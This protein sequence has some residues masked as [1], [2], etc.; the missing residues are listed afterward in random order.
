MTKAASP[1]WKIPPE[2]I[3]SDDCAVYVGRVIEDGEIKDEGTAY[4]VHEGEWVEML[5]CR[6]LSELL[7]LTDVEKAA[8]NGADYLRILCQELSQR[9]TAW[10]WTGMAGEA[11]PEPYNAPAVLERLTDDELM[12]LLSA[13]KGNE[14]SDA[15][16]NA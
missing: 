6:S 1:K 13:A 5:P 9:V 10:N 16:K 2:R 3:L 15:R 4:H 12:W 7:A 14:T 11:L 8:Q